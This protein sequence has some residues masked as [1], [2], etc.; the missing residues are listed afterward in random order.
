[1][2]AETPSAVWHTSMAKWQWRHNESCAV[3]TGL[4]GLTPSASEFSRAITHLR[5][6]NGGGA[7]RSSYDGGDQEFWR[8]FYDPWYELPLRYQA[9]QALNMPYDDWHRIRVIH[10]VSSLREVNRIPKDMRHHYKY[11]Y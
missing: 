1:M 2:H 9:H 3:T 4:L 11:F 7:E 10:S 5:G 6:M 8:K